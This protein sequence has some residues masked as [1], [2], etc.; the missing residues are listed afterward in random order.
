MFKKILSFPKVFKRGSAVAI[1]GVVVSVSV[2]ICY[3]NYTDKFNKFPLDLSELWLVQLIAL[4]CTIP[5]F[6]MF[7]FYN[8]VYR[9]VSK[10]EFFSM[11]L[12]IALANCLF[13]LSV[14]I[15]QLNLF[16]NYDFLI[17][18]TIQIISI[19]ASRLVVRVLNEGLTVKR[20][21]RRASYHSNVLIYGA[22][23]AGRQIAGALM[24]NSELK[25]LGYMDDD[26]N[27]QGRRING[28]EV[29]SPRAIDQLKEKYEIENILLAMPSVSK[30]Q[31]LDIIDFLIGKKM[32]VQTL[33]SLSDL[34]MGRVN[35]SD[36][37]EV[38]IEDILGREPVS[39]D[40][41]LM[42]KDIERKS[43]MISGA[44]GSIGSEI[45]VQVFSLNPSEIIL[46]EHSEYL[47]FKISEH[48]KKSQNVRRCNTKIITLLGSVTDKIRINQVLSEYNPDIIYH[49]AAYKH[50]PLVEE[51]IVLGVKNNFLGTLYLAQQAIDTKVEKFVL[52]STDKAVRPTNVMGTTKRLAEMVLQA[53]STKQKTTK[54]LMVRFGNV[55]NSSGSVVPIF[56]KQIE[57]GG[58]VTVTDREVTRYFMTIAEAASL[59]IQACSMTSSFPVEG[60]SAPVYL[61]DMGKPVKIFDLAVKL[62]ELSGLS[63]WT[64][65]AKNDGDIEI[66]I[67]GLRPGEK[68]FEELLIT[69]EDNKTE[70]AK[71]RV[72]NENYIGWEILSK[73]IPKI[74]NL[75]E[76]NDR[77]GLLRILHELVP[78]FTHNSR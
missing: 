63:Y 22:G 17:L 54:F 36:I 70:H 16:S 56:K 39:S 23:S 64:E 53:I 32:K 30:Q 11:A 6:V 49:A 4:L 78:E 40:L 15:L 25:A 10:P 9:Y 52:I 26:V 28:L 72:A 48:L 65:G 12:A 35:M 37:R 44:G 3:R 2:Y 31:K 46:F 21:N 41:S 20:H 55:L 34:Y 19:F 50:V 57:E 76:K 61:L 74:E 59:V 33:P 45:A 77:H 51:N 27:L 14:H 75:I 66:K 68:L 62:I 43:V 5:L 47:L 29:F 67:T 1:D 13:F 24:K 58:P 38:S 73:E 69:P 42:R 7:G 18:F 8:V 71:I 60:K